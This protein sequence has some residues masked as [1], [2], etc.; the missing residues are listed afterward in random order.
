VAL[1]A[2][3]HKIDENTLANFYQGRHRAARMK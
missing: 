3:H 1:A 2:K